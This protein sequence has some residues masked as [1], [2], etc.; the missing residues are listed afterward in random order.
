RHGR[1]GRA[2]V[3]AV[4]RQLSDLVSANL[5]MDR[6]LTVLVEQT[7]SSSFRAVLEDVQRQVRGGKPLSDAMGQFPRLF[8]LLLTSTLSAGEASGQL[9]NVLERVADHLEWEQNRRSQVVSALMYPAILLTVA[10]GASGFLLTFVVPR[11]AV[12]FKDLGQALPTPTQILLHLASFTREFWWTPVVGGVTVWFLGKAYCANRSGK[13]RVNRALL[14]L[15][16]VGP[17]ARQVVVGRCI[18]SLGTMLT[19]GVPMLFALE[20]AGK[21]AA[22]LVFE[23]AFGTAAGEVRHGESLHAALAGTR[24]FPPIVIHMAAVG[25]ETGSLA[26]MLIRVATSLEREVEMAQRRL[27][28]LMEPAVLL[29]MGMLVGFIVISILLPIF[30]MNAAIGG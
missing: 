7:D 4:V 22:N 12:I 16:V 21:A 20:L 8:P 25:E 29:F 2:E 27:I 23:D 26:T 24:A 30:Q 28:T 10:L 13:L 17:L 11:I 19:G 5:P 3:I 15:P 14:R 6:C 9:G 1:V 18:R